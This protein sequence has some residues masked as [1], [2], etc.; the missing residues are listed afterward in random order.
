M[1]EA[2]L[3]ILAIEDV[4]ADHLLTR[5]ALQQQGLQAEFLRVDRQSDLEAALDQDWDAVLS[6]YKVPGM[7]FAD[8]LRLIQDRKPDLPV[9]LLSGSIG[10]EGAVELLHL[11]LAD[12]ILK[13]HQTRLASAIHN[14]RARGIER[15]ARLAAEAALKASQAAA[16]NEQRQARLAALSL[17]EDAQAARNRAEAAHAALLESERKYRLLAENATDWIFWH[18]QHGQYHYVSDACLVISGYRPEEFLADAG[19]MLRILHPED[20]GA[21]IEHLDHDGQD[22]AT[23]DFRI[24]HRDGTTVWVGHRCRPIHDAEGHYLGR[25]GSNRDITAR[26]LSEAA[27][28]RE[29]ENMKLILD[30]APIGI[31][32]QDGTGKLSFVNRAFSMAM[33]I[34][35]E[36][37]LAV[38]HY[39]ELIPTEYQ[40]Q[41][42]ASDAKALANPEVTV[43]LQRLPFV[44]GKVHDLRVIKAVKRDAEGEP[45]ALV[46]LSIDITEELRQA[47]ELRKLSLAVEQSP[48]SIVITN[49]DAKIEY[50]N[51]AFLRATGYTQTEVLGQ[52]PRILHSG[53]TPPETFLALWDALT[54]GQV[55]KGEFQN[56]RK[57][58]TEYVEFAII[59]PIRQ[60]DG[61]ITHYVAVKED[62]TEKKRL[63]QELDAHR[64]HLEELVSRRTDELRRQSQSLQALIDNLPHMAWMKDTQGRFIAANR[65]I[66]E[67]NGLTT[68]DLI[69]KTDLELWPREMA[70]RYLADDAEVM[71]NRRQKTTEGPVA[72]HPDTLYETYKA[73]ILDADGTVLGTVGF[74]RDI[75]PQR[76]MEAELARR[77]L[78]A[79]AA[80]QAKSAFLAN[81]SHEIRTP[82]N[83]MLG[84]THLL[85]RDGAT[86]RQ[87]ERLVKIDHSAHHLLSIINDIL[88]LSKIEAGKL[89]LEQTSFALESVVGEV[90]TM[91]APAADNK[92]LR[93]EVDMGTVPRWLRG[94]QT[95]LR[96][97]LL[98]YAGNA[99]KFT[100]TGRIAIRSRLTG[101]DNGRLLV[102]F[103][104]QDTG[105]GIPREK[106]GMLFQAFEQADST[107]TRKFGGTG[108]GLAITHRLANLMGGDTGV[109]STPGEGSLFWFTASLGLGQGNPTESQ[110]KT[111]LD[112]RELLSASQSGSRILLVEDNEINREVAL[113]M[114]S[115]LGLVVEYAEDGM[116]A[117]EKARTARYDLILMDVQMPRMDGLAATRAIRALHD[118]GGYVPI[119]AMTANAFDEDRELCLAAG[120]NDFIGKPVDPDTF[121]QTLLR[122][123]PDRSD[124]PTH[125]VT[126]IGATTGL[127]REPDASINPESAAQLATL[128]GMDVQRALRAVRGNVRS[129]VDLLHLFVTS[130]AHDLAKLR[131]ARAADDLPAVRRTVHTMKGSSATLGLEQIHQLLVELENTLVVGDVVRIERLVASIEH[132]YARFAAALAQLPDPASGLPSDPANLEALIDH[133][134][135]MLAADDTAVIG[136]V[137]ECSAALA[138]ELGEAYSRF[139]R[140]VADFD[141]PD[142]LTTLHVARARRRASS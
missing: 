51:E 141:L 104:V 93:I 19:L 117:L 107:T 102:R 26:K 32:L 122:W 97:A 73:P 124:T 21:Y 15:R 76:D 55:W 90:A 67:L 70:E 50:V 43:T 22:D 16:F 10:D 47:E 53:G 58:G 41:C 86:P 63:G 7:V 110:R 140:Q 128:P 134:E 57:D 112:A 89:E 142:A 25:T 136:K 17:M 83:A 42:L 123:L 29:R 101:E 94:D 62:V 68:K 114:L 95:R 4:E 38:D 121:Y 109:E 84:L 118:W 40:P 129:L 64:H 92:G 81:M 54:H 72:T 74:A 14:A 108:L 35:E 116:V 36:R 137:R 139:E 1:S 30:H 71:A 12:F 18:D 85:R 13:D 135:A 115:N 138:I 133:I 24:R 59:A 80:T 11:G 2:P 98:N 119:L 82:M 130:H 48:E 120:M 37:F 44:D 45:V 49:L 39:A 126:G 65:V 27:L 3:R 88:D 127:P 60:A 131:E 28:A 91:I 5:R 52:N 9:I 105:V 125:V 87:V 56:R 111:S 61:R 79:E 6:D 23:L 96:Q 8:A 20:R 132:E 78:E 113:D 99:V 77:A 106:I 103:E 75:K 66:A 100:D 46:G 69:G 33:G 31:W 34:P